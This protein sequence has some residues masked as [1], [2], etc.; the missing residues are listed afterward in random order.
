MGSREARALALGFLANSVSALV[1]GLLA[2]FDLRIAYVLSAGSAIAALTVAAF[3]REPPRGRAHAPL[4]QAITCVGRLGEPVLLWI[5]AFAVGMTIFNHVPWE[6]IQPYLG[7][8]VGDQEGYALTPAASGVAIAITMLLSF[9]ASR[10]AIPI[11]DRIGVPLTLLATMLLSGMIIAGMIWVHPVI[12]A[13]LVLR[14]VPMAVMTPVMNAAIHPRVQSGIRATYLSMQSLAGR[15]AFSA[16]LFFVSLA[17]GG[18]EK[19][20]PPVLRDVSLVFAGATAGLLVLLGVFAPWIA[21]RT[22]G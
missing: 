3:F 22:R 8:L 6:F 16:S 5:F 11:R 12:V 10:I 4:R 13:L 17:V 19:L 14:S 9:G 18:T 1:G 15:L 7:F 21:R 20:T 2:G